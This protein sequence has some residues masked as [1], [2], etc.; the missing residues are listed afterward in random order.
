MRRV[1]DLESIELGRHGLVI[2]HNEK[3]GVLLPQVPV[4]EGWSRA[5]YL[6][7]LCYKAGLP[8]DCW[9]DQPALY[10]FTA[11]VFGE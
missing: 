9:E 2:I 5:E 11:I 6:E 3:Q 1:T 4:A 8:G 10:A 7:N